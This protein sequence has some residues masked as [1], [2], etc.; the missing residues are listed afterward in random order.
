MRELENLVAVGSLRR[1]PRSEREFD[2]LVRAGRARL[3]DADNEALALESRFDLAYNGAHALA[4]AALRWHGYRSEN[5][6]VAFQSLPHTTGVGPTV[7]RVLA[8]A[9]AQRNLL[10][11]EGGGAVDERLLGD[12]IAAAR[13]VETAVAV[14]RAGDA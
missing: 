12:L 11:Y 4:L 10:E 14:L 9:H 7:W 5:R 3:G 13:A 1:E 6:Y 8:S 2:A